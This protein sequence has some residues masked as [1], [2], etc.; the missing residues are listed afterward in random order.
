MMLNGAG[1]I[2]V[3]S[4]PTLRSLICSPLFRQS[5]E[6]DDPMCQKTSFSEHGLGVYAVTPSE[7]QK[8]TICS[9]LAG[10]VQECMGE[11]FVPVDM[12][13]PP[14]SSF[15]RG[16]STLFAGQKESIDLDAIFADK[17]S[18][19]ASGSGMR[20]IAKTIPGPSA[21]LEQAT[22]RGISAGQA[23]NLALQALHER[24]EKLG[25]TVD[26][27]ERLKDNAMTLSQRTGK[28][29]EKYE[30]K[31]WLRLHPP[32]FFCLGRHIVNSIEK[33]SI[34]FIDGCRDTRV[35]AIINAF[36]EYYGDERRTTEILDYDKKGQEEQQRIRSDYPRG[37]EDKGAIPF[38]A[39][40]IPFI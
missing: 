38:M 35:V 29:V 19:T 2:V 20:S 11:L 27:T 3:L 28:L 23:A 10:Q 1:Q 32:H 8:F 36:T 30:K 22:T 24:G 6:L 5:V 18:N 31:K 9:E 40:N 34:S 4:L 21:S 7:V 14:K 26:A 37:T 13:E 15:L 12:P 16:V 25:A 17:N 33:I 39:V